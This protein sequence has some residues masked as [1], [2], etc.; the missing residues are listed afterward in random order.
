[1]SG[2]QPLIASSDALRRRRFGDVLLFGVTAVELA[3]L[4]RLTPSFTFVD[5]I[6]LAQHLLVLG[7]AFARRAPTAQ[8]HSFLSGIA[9]TVSYA[10]PYAQIAWL[11]VSAGESTSQPAGVILVTCAAVWSV[12]GLVSLGTSF[13]IRPA[14]RR[15]ITRGPYQVVR[16]PL[17]ASYLLSDIGYN[18]QE[19]NVGSLVLTVAGWVSLVYRIQA[20]ERVLA[21]DVRWPAYISA[22][23]Y[24]L[25][26]KLW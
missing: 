12:A 16:H 18:L 22:V 9:V 5:W 20:E 2:R 15:L 19:W 6:Y 1:V 26:P 24:R 8:D 14:L 25:V 10:Y 17:Y 13:G 11:G 3:I 7:L 4:V 21:A 23:R